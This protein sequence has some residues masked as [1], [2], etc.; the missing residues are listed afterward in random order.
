MKVGIIGLSLANCLTIVAERMGTIGEYPDKNS[1]WNIKY[2][3]T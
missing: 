3:C 2:I 1:F